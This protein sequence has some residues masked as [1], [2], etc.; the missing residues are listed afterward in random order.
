MQSKGLY[1][2][3]LMTRLSLQSRF[4][5]W[6]TYFAFGI[7]R[8]PARPTKPRKNSTF[9]VTGCLGMFPAKELEL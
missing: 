8:L 3:A 5:G 6:Q 7:S 4:A 1:L 9:P 2:A